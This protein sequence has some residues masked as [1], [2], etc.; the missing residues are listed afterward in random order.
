MVGIRPF[1]AFELFFGLA[2]FGYI[3]DD[4]QHANKLVL[5]VRQRRRRN[6]HIDQR[7]VFAAHAR[8]IGVAKALLALFGQLL[9]AIVFLALD[10]T[11]QI[12]P[13]QLIDPIPHD[14]AERWIGKGQILLRIGDAD[15]GEGRLYQGAVELLAFAQFI[16]DLQALLLRALQFD[17]AGFQFADALSQMNYFITAIHESITSGSNIGR[18]TYCRRDPPRLT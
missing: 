13:D 1:V 5:L 17:E 11:R 8:L 16:L 2:Q 3:E 18:H 6:K 15:P 12:D 7:S 9:I 10:K 14:L 4:G